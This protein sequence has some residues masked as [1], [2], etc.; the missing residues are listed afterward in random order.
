MR[1]IWTGRLKPPLGRLDGIEMLRN[2]LDRNHK[3]R[4]GKLEFEKKMMYFGSVAINQNGMSEQDYFDLVNQING[5]TELYE[6]DNDVNAFYNNSLEMEKQ[7]YLSE[8]SKSYEFVFI[9]IHGS[10]TTQWLGNSTYVYYNEIKGARPDALFSVLASCSNGNFT[11]ENY[12]A[13]WYLFSGNSLIVTGNTVV[14]MLIG[15]DSPEFLKDYV[16]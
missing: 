16:P 1:D 14:T 4:T 8:L 10:A 12:F 5:F 13:G 2:Y 15:S 3:Y 11:Q 6:S 7:I 9:N